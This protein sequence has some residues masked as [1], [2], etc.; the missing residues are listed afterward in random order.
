MISRAKEILE[1]EIKALE[2]L[3]MSPEIEICVGLLATCQGKIVFTGMG[4][5]GLVAQ[6]IAATLSSTGTPAVFMHP[7]EARHGDLGIISNN[8]IIVAMSNS[9]KT[10]EVLLTLELCKKTFTC[11]I[12]GICSTRESELSKLCDL[13]LEIGKVEE[14]CPFGLAPTSSTTAMIVLGDILSILTMEEKKFTVEEYAKRH[15]GGYLGELAKEK[16]SKV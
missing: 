15:H 6:K 12:I 3:P 14:A 5:A 16:S 2:Q 4:K 7:G 9:G 8:D 13:V 11:P 10:H 1:L